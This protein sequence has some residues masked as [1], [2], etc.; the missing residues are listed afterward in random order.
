MFTVEHED[1]FSRVVVLDETAQLEDIVI[2]FYED[3]VIINQVEAFDN[4]D[5]ELYNTVTLSYKMLQDIVA[6]YNSPE[7]LYKIDNKI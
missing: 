6:A 4:T 5:I 3:E 7:G 1:V 2:D